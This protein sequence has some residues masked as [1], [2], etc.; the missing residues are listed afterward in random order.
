MSAVQLPK[1]TE[2]NT[3]TYV[4]I[5]N[6]V[7]YCKGF[8]V[9]LEDGEQFRYSTDGT[10][11]NSALSPYNTPGLN[12]PNNS[13]VGATVLYIKAVTDTANCVFQPGKRI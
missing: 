8:A 4:P 6:D 10:D 3:S 7:C 13:V 11:E 2:V 12:F 5:V 9:W 1:V